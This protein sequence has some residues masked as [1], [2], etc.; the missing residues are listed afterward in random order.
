[1]SGYDKRGEGM[2]EETMQTPQM[3]WNATLESLKAMAFGEQAFKRFSAKER[4]TLDAAIN[5][6]ENAYAIE[7]CNLELALENEDLE[8]KLKK[9]TD[10]LEAVYKCPAC[11]LDR[12]DALNKIMETYKEVKNK[13]IH[14]KQYY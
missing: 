8:E 1:M 6:Y 9:L 7:T 2:T 10:V 13:C 14:Q 5:V 3:N 12:N 11:I 4:E